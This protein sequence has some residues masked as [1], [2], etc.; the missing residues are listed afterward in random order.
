MRFALWRLCEWRKARPWHRSRDLHRGARRQS[1]IAGPAQC[2]GRVHPAYASA[3]TGPRTKSE[4]WTFPSAIV[5]LWWVRRC[6]TEKYK[7]SCVF[8]EGQQTTQTTSADT[9]AQTGRIYHDPHAVIL[10][11]SINEHGIAPRARSRRS[12]YRRR[13]VDD[14]TRLFPPGN[15]FFRPNCPDA[16][17]L[18][19]WQLASRN[20][21]RQSHLIL[22]FSHFLF[23][24]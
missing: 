23:L 12:R 5:T 21:P 14:G 10:P 15:T 20:S 24:C 17:G 13:P 2:D 9:H 3:L 7:Y 22:P 19:Q 18:P 4:S 16:P 6:A 1:R 11:G 8:A